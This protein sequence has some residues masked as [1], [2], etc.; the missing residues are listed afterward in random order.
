MICVLEII[1]GPATGMK[2]WLKR[3]QRLTIGRLSSC[4]FSVAADT[5]MSRNHLIVEGLESGFRLRDVGSSNGTYVNDLPISVVELCN[6]DQIKAGTSVFE[7]TLALGDTAPAESLLSTELDDHVPTRT[8]GANSLRAFSGEDTLRY[9][10]ESDMRALHPGQA[11]GAVARG[12]ERLKSVAPPDPVTRGKATMGDRSHT[13][14]SEFA[15][16]SVA[17]NTL[18]TALSSFLSEFLAPV[19]GVLWKQARRS[20]STSSTEVVDKLTRANWPA[21]YSL[22]LNRSQLAA[23]QCNALDYAVSIGQ[24]RQLTTTLFLLEHST[25]SVVLEF[26][27]RCLTKDAALCVVSSLS[28]RNAWV[29][30]AIDLLSYPSMFSELMRKSPSRAEE[31]VRDVH[32]VLFEPHANGELHLLRGS[33]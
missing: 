31:F 28:L 21:T 7:V 5:H 18:E 1:A 15:P 16:Q 32:F 27:K 2:C 8:M 30:Q 13:N 10:L 6:G 26:Y 22:I 25:A 4:D 20:Q 29:E 24:A 19:D 12:T 14:A 9:E 23:Q 3:D 17:A 33:A 11:W